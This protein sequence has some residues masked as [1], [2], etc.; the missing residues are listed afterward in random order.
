MNSGKGE[1]ALELSYVLQNVE[2]TTGVAVGRESETGHDFFVARP[3]SLAG[4]LPIR[5]PDQRVEPPNKLRKHLQRRDE[6]VTTTNV[7]EFV[8]QNR[9]DVR[10]QIVPQEQ[11]GRFT[12]GR[13]SP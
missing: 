6:A 7:D 11:F 8:G 13:N 12:D 1:H 3:L 4:N 9:L 2:Q 5:P 10:L